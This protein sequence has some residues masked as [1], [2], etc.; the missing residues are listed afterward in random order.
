MAAQQDTIDADFVIVGAGSAGCVMAARLSE[1]PATRV[2]L[3]EAGGEDRNLWIHIPLGF[4]KT[5]ADP[6]STGATRPSP[7]RR[8]TAAASSGRAARCSAARPR[9]T[10]WSISAA[11][12]ED[13]DHWRQLGNT[14]WS[15]DD[16]LPYFR[17][18]EHQTRGARRIPWH[19]R[20]ALRLR[21]AGPPPDLRGVHQERAWTSAIRAT[22][23]STARPRKASA[24][25]R[26]RRATAGAAPPRSA[27]CVR[28]CSGRNL[29]VITDALTEKIAVRGPPRHRRR[30]SAS[31]GELRTVR[32]RARSSCAAARS[33]RRNCCCCPGIGPQQHLA[34]VRHP[35]RAPSAGRRAEPAGPL[36]GAAS[37]CK[38][39]LPITVNDVML[40]NAKKLKAGLEYYLFRTG[41]LDHGRRAGGAVR[42]HPAGTRL[43]G[44]EVCRGRRSV[45]TGRRTGC[46]SG[47]GFSLIVYQ[48]RPESRGEIKLKIG[49][50][51]RCAG[52]APELPGHRDRPAH[53]RRRAEARPPPARDAAH[54]A[55]CICS[56]PN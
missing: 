26:P 11:R 45:P 52:D 27:I 1:D 56:T 41:P 53:H 9:S 19:R 16:V 14:G 15:S 55:F 29:R 35:G 46:T 51:G 44:R 23:T 33:T 34:R 54:A 30:R 6:R 32:A 49:E 50:P 43:A 12:H 36:L 48:L 3:L 13:F 39:R 38:C 4:G 40:S 42:A 24:T 25:T 37:S 21:H 17:R 5:F 18:A 20:P 28:R 8:R 7:T 47:P 10:A 2:V 31:D 22:T